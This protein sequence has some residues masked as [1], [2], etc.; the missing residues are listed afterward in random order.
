ML[1]TVALVPGTAPTATATYTAYTDLNVGGS[2]HVISA[3]YQGDGTHDLSDSSASPLLQTITALPVTLSGSRNYDGTATAVA[4]I[5]TIGNDLDGV[6][7]TLSGSA[8]L[9]SAN[10][11]L[12]TL[13]SFA[14]LTLGGTAAGNYTFAG[15]S[16][17]VRINPAPGAF[18]FATTLNTAAT[19]ASAKVIHYASDAGVT[20]SVS[21][22]SSPSA[23]SGTVTLNGDST[24]TYTPQTGYTGADSFNYTL[25]DNVGGSSPGTVTVQVNAGNISSVITTYIVNGDGSFTIT[26]SGFPG[27]TYGVQAADTVAGSWASIG[28]TTALS[29]G[30]VQYTDLDAHNHPSR[31]YRLVQ[32]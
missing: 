31:V 18:A 27:T 20:L 4:S 22:V 25:I 13:S 12:E 23:Q 15:A 19:F 16:G 3:Y 2:P 10:G 29:N 32:P 6:N 26:A 11:G 8:T 17:A 5:L 21:A 9:A 14:G 24:I 7:L 30:L 28:T 1:A